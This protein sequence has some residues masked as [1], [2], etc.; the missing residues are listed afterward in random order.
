[1]CGPTVRSVYR[2]DPDVTSDREY[3]PGTAGQMEWHFVACPVR[4]KGRLL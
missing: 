3:H 2:Q 1:M 4:M